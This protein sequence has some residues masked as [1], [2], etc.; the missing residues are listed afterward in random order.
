MKDSTLGPHRPELVLGIDPGLRVTGYGLVARSG[1]TDMAL[2]EA[3]TLEGGGPK[4]SMASR[5]RNLFEGMDSLVGEYQPEA[6]AI[7]QLYSH[8]AHPRTAILMAHA[9]GVLSLAA[10]LH[11]VEVFDYSATEVKAGLTGNGRAPKAQVQRAIQHALKLHQE[12]QPAD[13][14]DALALA[15]CHLS[16]T[17]GS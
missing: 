13:V 3:G 1:S 16:R 9:R 2:V 4:S 14:A 7:E 5:L 8:Y 11:D 15:L 12:P 10:A 17:R 6:V